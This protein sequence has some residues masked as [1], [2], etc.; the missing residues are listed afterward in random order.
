MSSTA[1]ACCRLTG[2][3][4]FV[5][6]LGGGGWGNPFDRDVQ[7]VLDD[8]LDEYVSVDGAARDY[9]VVLTGSLADLTL[10]DRIYLGNSVRGLVRAELIQQLL[11]G[12]ANEFIWLDAGQ[13]I[14]RTPDL[15]FMET[16]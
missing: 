2:R 4:A 9:A 6:D 3:R 15:K 14:N 11:D 13:I 10:A 12:T 1:A 16:A 7:T 8:V 5:T